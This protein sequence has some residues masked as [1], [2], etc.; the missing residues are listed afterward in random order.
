[1]FVGWNRQR[2]WISLWKRLQRLRT[3][4]RALRTALR[5]RIRP[6]RVVQAAGKPSHQSHRQRTLPKSNAPT[7]SQRN[8][9][10]ADASAATRGSGDW[11]Q[12]EEDKGQ[13]TRAPLASQASAFGAE[14]VSRERSWAG[15]PAIARALA[16]AAASTFWQRRC[17]FRSSVLSPL[18]CFLGR[19]FS[20]SC[21][22]AEH[23]AS[24]CV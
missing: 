14:G 12:D 24:E 8:V 4:L 3:S 19:F 13:N 18:Y 11:R 2:S 10:G 17:S 22:A 21:S 23:K 7:G 6:L 9:E 15:N 16:T 20:S 1:M 5:P